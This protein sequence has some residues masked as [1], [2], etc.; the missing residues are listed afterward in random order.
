MVDVAWSSVY[1]LACAARQSA[2]T[3]NVVGCG[4]GLGKR[5]LGG[6]C[7]GAQRVNVISAS[8]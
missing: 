7:R 3:H 8:L 4:I 1:A 5:L 6:R 2:G